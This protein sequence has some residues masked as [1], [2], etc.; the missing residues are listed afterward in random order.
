M[1]FFQPP[2]P[3]EYRELAGDEPESFFYAVADG[4]R[5]KGVKRAAKRKLT[6]FARRFGDASDMA[7]DYLHDQK[8]ILR[9]Y[10]EISPHIMEA[11]RF[12][13]DILMERRRLD[14][15]DLLLVCQSYPHIWRPVLGNWL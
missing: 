8:N 3:E 11:V 5:P 12:L 1:K 15:Q 10:V 13:A 6:L 9:Q 7:Q 14:G 4:W 2:I